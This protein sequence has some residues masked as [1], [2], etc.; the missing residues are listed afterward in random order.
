MPLLLLHLNFFDAR[1]RILLHHGC[2]VADLGLNQQIHA[3]INDEG[4]VVKI[5]LLKYCLWLLICMHLG[6]KMTREHARSGAHFAA[7]AGF[8]RNP[9]RRYN[10]LPL[11]PG[12]NEVV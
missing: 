1:I 4:G 11:K 8:I 12:K 5:G 9:H 6:S 7:L 2:M 10:V 3:Q